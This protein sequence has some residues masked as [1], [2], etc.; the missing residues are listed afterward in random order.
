MNLK[1]NSPVIGGT[2]SYNALRSR[3]IDLVAEKGEDYRGATGRY[4]NPDGSPG[5]LLGALAAE[6]GA[7]RGKLGGHNHGGVSALTE[8]GYLVPADHKTELA[9][10]RLQHFNDT[11]QRW[12]D[13]VQWAFG[14]SRRELQVEIEA[15]RAPAVTFDAE[16]YVGWV[17]S[18]QGGELKFDLTK[19]FASEAQPV[20]PHVL[21][22]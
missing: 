22:A 13:A 2:I 14:M 20:V 6:D 18:Y 11:G 9:L 8:L 12:F 17:E 7:T 4:F 16:H 1:L 15:R 10:Q 19:S 3:C 5:C 21:A